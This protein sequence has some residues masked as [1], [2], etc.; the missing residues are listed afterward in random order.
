MLITSLCFAHI[1]N[2]YNN[3]VKKTFFKFPTKRILD[4]LPISDEEKEKIAYKNAEKLLGI[5]I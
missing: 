4:S 1:Y 5:E 2:D 3:D